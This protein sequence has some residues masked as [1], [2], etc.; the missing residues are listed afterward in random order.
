MGAVD[1][2]RRRLGRWLGPDGVPRAG[3][4]RRCRRAQEHERG[5]AEP[6]HRSAYI[7][8]ATARHYLNKVDVMNVVAMTT[9][10]Q[11]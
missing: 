2:D 7:A 9:C 11:N 6:G 1:S 3:A 8:R 10:K 5:D 4:S